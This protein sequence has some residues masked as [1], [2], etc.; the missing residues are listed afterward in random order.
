[1]GETPVFSPCR[2]NCLNIKPHIYTGASQIPVNYLSVGSQWAFSVPPLLSRIQ[3]NAIMWSN[4]QT[5]VEHV[6][7]F[8]VNNDCFEMCQFFQWKL[9][10]D[11]SSGAVP[12]QP[13]QT[14]VRHVQCFQSALWQ[15]LIFRPANR[16]VHH[17][18]SSWGSLVLPCAPSL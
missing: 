16:A 11:G 2:F 4:Q 9:H 12:C 7:V 14:G 18:V 15:R 6:A 1:M 17:F 3:P 10:R 8:A 13:S 5:Q